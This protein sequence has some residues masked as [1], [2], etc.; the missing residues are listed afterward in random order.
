MLFNFIRP[1]K[2][3]VSRDEIAF[4]NVYRRFKTAIRPAGDSLVRLGGARTFGFLL[5]ESFTYR[6][7]EDLCLGSCPSA[8]W[9][10]FGAQSPGCLLEISF[11][12]F[13][14]SG[15]AG[16]ILC[17]ERRVEAY[18]FV[19]NGVGGRQCLCRA[20]C[21]ACE[22]A[23]VG[24]SSMR[25]KFVKSAILSVFGHDHGRLVGAVAWA[26]VGNCGKFSRFLAGDHT[27]LCYV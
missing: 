16:M 15:H 4:K 27:S 5:G 19:P 13:A 14:Q 26:R 7:V 22:Q 2:A 12:F 17:G 18:F 1:L 20:G 8:L 9:T 6:V 10:S 11:L 25:Y 3:T 24:A 23:F 21:V